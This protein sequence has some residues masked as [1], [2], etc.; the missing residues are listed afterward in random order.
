M[1]EWDHD[2]LMRQAD[3]PGQASTAPAPRAARRPAL[4]RSRPPCRDR[5]W[6]AGQSMHGARF[7]QSTQHCH[8]YILIPPSLLTL[9]ELSLRRAAATKLLSLAD[10]ARSP[11]RH[12]PLSARHPSTAS[13][14][15]RAPFERRTPVSSLYL[16]Y[17]AIWRAE[18]LLIGR[19]PL[20]KIWR[21][22]TP[23][24]RLVI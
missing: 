11:S 1:L 16:V 8:S 20:S 5:T 9:R 22:L 4:L 7:V 2:C 24:G 21:N 18:S 10:A 17:C 3:R 12:R 6:P 23:F 19:S 14:A 15:L 13:L